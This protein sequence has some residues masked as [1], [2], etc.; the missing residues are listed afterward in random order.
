MGWLFA[1]QLSF[2]RRWQM[3]AKM[4]ATAGRLPRR[5]AT[6]EQ[7]KLLRRGAILDAAQALFDAESFDAVT[8]ARVAAQAKLAKGTLYLY[9]PSREALFLALLTQQ[10]EAFFQAL[11][12]ALA[13]PMTQAQFAHYLAQDLHARP[14]LLR[15]ISVMHTVLEHNIDL[16]TASAFKHMLAGHAQRS[17]SL[18][19]Q[20]V[21][22]IHSGFGSR[23]LMWLHALAIGLHHL[24]TP[25]PVVRQAIQADAS[26]A[27]FSVDFATE[28]NAMLKTLLQAQPG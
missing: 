24:A 4:Q 14:R 12:A 13:R 10:F 2:A 16:A 22:S 7:Q 23:L 21:A 15:L 9:F 17:G 26:L 20:Q 28:L 19:E 3:S 27:V 11:D 25:A 6:T 8:M 18:I 1:Q 5:R